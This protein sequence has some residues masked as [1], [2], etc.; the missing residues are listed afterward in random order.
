MTTD[1]TLSGDRFEI[2]VDG[3]R[4]GLTQFVD[5][6]GQRIFFHTEVGEEYAGQGLAGTLVTR[7]LDATREAGLRVVP[8]CP[9]VKRFVGSHEE[10]A[11]IVDAVTAD[12]LA[13]VRAGQAG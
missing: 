1:V 8:V 10:Y 4:A 12:A 7:A 13:T 3:T 11:D 9:Y 5:S 6:G 2:A